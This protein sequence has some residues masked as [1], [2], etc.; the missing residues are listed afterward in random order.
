MQIDLSQFN[1]YAPSGRTNQSIEV[2]SLSGGRSS[3]YTLMALINGGFGKKEK[4]IICFQNTG[5]EDETCYVFLKELEEAIQLPIV[6]LEYTLTQKFI[7]ELVFSSF[8][9][10]KFD[11]GEYTSISQI[12]DVKKLQSFE[13]VKSPAN[14]WYKEGYSNSKKSVRQVNFNTASRNGKP[15]ADVFLYKCA[16]RIMKGEGLILPNAAQRWCT[17]DMKE[18]TMHTWLKNNGIKEFIN[19]VGMRFDDIFGIVNA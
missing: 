16:I 1:S 13:F 14:F 10:D 3:A 9:Y 15:F 7:D 19:Y 4:D 18:K 11:K 2:V 5:K 8:S 17:G 12:L 6:W